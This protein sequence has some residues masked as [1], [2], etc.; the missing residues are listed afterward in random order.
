MIPILFTIDT[1]SEDTE[2]DIITE[3]YDNS[4]NEMYAIAL[5]ILKN[6]DDADDAVYDA[7][8]GL[9]R[10]VDKVK[11][12]RPGE[13]PYLAITY[14]RY[15]S[16]NYL[17]K[18]NR[19]AVVPIDND[20]WEEGYA[21]SDIPDESA[22]VAELIIKNEQAARI[23]KAIKALPPSQRDYV[24][25]K[26]YYDYKVADISAITGMPKKRISIYLNRAKKKLAEALR[27]EQ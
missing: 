23:A 25:L 15:A 8:F 3:I 10:D 7:I 2:R 18:R 4:I 27:D 19:N 9:I 5:R 20:D 26:Y 21:V 24:V 11:Q 1:I 17:R 6:K 13:R 14:A 12:V 16:F 22:D